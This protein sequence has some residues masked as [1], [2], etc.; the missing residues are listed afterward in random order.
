M[1]PDVIRLNPRRFDRFGDG[2]IQDAGQKRYPRAS[3]N[4]LS[5]QTSWSLAAIPIPY[6]V[7]GVMGAEVR[8]DDVA[9]SSSW[10]ECYGE[11]VRSR[12]GNP[13]RPQ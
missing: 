13:A 9:T 5:A 10:L 6:A 3:G 4:E 8:H 11:R 12:V 7:C 1:E 2:K